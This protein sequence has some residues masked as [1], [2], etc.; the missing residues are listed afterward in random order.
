MEHL[1]LVQLFAHTGKFDGLAGDRA[2]RQGRAAPG[3]AV[4]LGQHDAVDAQR[5]VEGGGHVDRVLPGHGVHHQQD[6]LRGHRR[7][8]VFQLVHQLLVDVQ[9]A[10]GIQNHI[11]VAVIPGVSHRLFG[12]VHRVCRAHLKHR[13]AGLLPHHLQL[14]DG[15]GAVDVAGHQQRPV[16]LLFEHQA[17]L[18]GMGGL[19]GAL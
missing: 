19:A 2:H 4:Q 6:F 3:V 14:G 13:D 10:G 8:D 9:P 5:L 18:A 17:Q 7:L 11:V 1:Q 16:P 12:D 15:G